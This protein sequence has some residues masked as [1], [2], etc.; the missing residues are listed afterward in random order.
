MRFR[1]HGR[2]TGIVRQYV[3]YPYHFTRAFELD[4]D[5]PELLTLYQQS[6]SGGMYRGDKLSSEISVNAGAAAHI[7]TQASTVVH[8]CQGSAAETALHAI[9]EHDAFLACTPD[10][11]ILFPN[12]R[13][14]MTT[15]VDMASSAVVLLHD[16]FDR[17]DP[18]A[19]HRPFDRIEA[20]VE[21]R[22]LQGE[23]LVRDRMSV[24]GSDVASP[25]TSPMGQWRIS[26][27]LFLVGPAQRLPSED[28]FRAALAV[29]GVLVGV[30]ALPNDAGL[31]G[32]VLASNAHSAQQAAL[33]LFNLAVERRFGV[34]P[35]PRRK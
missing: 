27:S 22:T 7:T 28:E 32:R 19:N 21:F 6:S 18:K 24:L 13:V 2:R 25:Q 30:C 16:F 11:L 9:V 29:P 31:I 23:M 1:R 33:R 15:T 14:K 3:S 20:Q 4:R 5:I 10:P 12:A 17:H 26:G 8:D 34:A 35:Q